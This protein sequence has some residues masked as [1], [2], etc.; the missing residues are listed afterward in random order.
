M[1]DSGIDLRY[2]VPEEIV[3]N[4]DIVPEEIVWNL[5]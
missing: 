1:A 2:I 4:V 3:R 5:D